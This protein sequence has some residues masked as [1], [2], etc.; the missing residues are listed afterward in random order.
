MNLDPVAPALC[1]LQLSLVLS[2]GVLSY[3]LCTTK[4]FW[5]ALFKCNLNLL[6]RNSMYK[7]N[8]YCINRLLFYLT[9]FS[10]LDLYDNVEM[11]THLHF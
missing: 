2:K 4:C 8:I 1:K 10:P 9:D 11:Y 5:V 6:K 3:N 7:L